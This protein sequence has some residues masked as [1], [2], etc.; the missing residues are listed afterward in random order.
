MATNCVLSEKQKHID[1]ITRIQ[2]MFRFKL[3]HL[4]FIRRKETIE[5]NTL[6]LRRS[7]YSLIVNGFNKIFYIENLDGKF[8]MVRL[9]N[10]TFY[11]LS[12]LH[13]I[14]N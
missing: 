4:Q 10:A 14:R 8:P 3:A 6:I 12:F 13:K 9:P 1:I 2:Q 7:I 5:V 11:N